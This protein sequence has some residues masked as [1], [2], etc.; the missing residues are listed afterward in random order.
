MNRHRTPAAVRVAHGTTRA[1]RRLIW[2]L[3]CILFAATCSIATTIRVRGDSMTPTLQN[4]DYCVVVPVLFGRSV[5]AR[6]SV[7]VFWAP[8]DPHNPSIKRV[9]GVPGD[10]MP[11]SSVSRRLKCEAS[12]LSKSAASGAYFMVG[13]NTAR[14]FDSRT[15]GFVEHQAVLGQAVAIVWPFSR[16]GLIRRME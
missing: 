10:C 9:R 14:S 3:G 4:G 16:L 13:D 8:G 15:Y 11:V 12:Q 1:S 6:G 2:P 7:V 5:I